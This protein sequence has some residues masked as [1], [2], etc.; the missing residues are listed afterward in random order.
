[1]FRMRLHILTILAILLKMILENLFLHET[2]RTA[3]DFNREVSAAIPGIDLA[4]AGEVQTVKWRFDG[5]NILGVVQHWH[6]LA[7]LCP[8]NPNF[9]NPG[10]IK[11]RVKFLYAGDKKIE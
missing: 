9:F 3:A 11:I 1:M 5:R 2:C 7:I 8:V 6:R 4:H 10:T